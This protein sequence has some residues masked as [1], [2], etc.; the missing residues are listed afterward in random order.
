MLHFLTITGAL[1]RGKVATLALSPVRAGI[2]TIEAIVTVKSCRGLQLR[3]HGLQPA[4]Y[5]HFDFFEFGEQET[6]AR[7][8]RN[9]VFDQQV[10]GS[11]VFGDNGS[12]ISPNPTCCSTV[13]AI[14]VLSSVSLSNRKAISKNI[15]SR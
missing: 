15:S 2:R 7:D 4:P 3:A 9:P 10:K 13:A 12:F 1:V 11:A 5:V 14:G 6:H 8:G